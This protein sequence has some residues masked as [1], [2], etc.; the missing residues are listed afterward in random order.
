MTPVSPPPPLTPCHHCT[1]VSAIY[2]V[3]SSYRIVTSI[4]DRSNIP[5]LPLFRDM[6]QALRETA[7][8][9]APVLAVV[10]LVVGGVGERK[11]GR[12]L[13]RRS[14]HPMPVVMWMVRA[15]GGTQAVTAGRAAGQGGEREGASRTACAPCYQWDG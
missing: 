11:Y 4:W 6:N 9:T 1:K 15:G 8:E 10:V 12:F 13:C 3:E 2:F 5:A 14:P 7:L